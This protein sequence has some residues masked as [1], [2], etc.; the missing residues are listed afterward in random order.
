[1]SSRRALLAVAGVTGALVLGA[2]AR[3]AGPDFGA[4]REDLRPEHVDGPDPVR[5]STRSTQQVDSELGA[6]RC[7]LFSTPGTYRERSV[8]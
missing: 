5:S 4:E 2:Q 8:G 6:G 3:A 1:M 7:A